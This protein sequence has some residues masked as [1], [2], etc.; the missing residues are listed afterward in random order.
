M[1]V[2]LKLSLASFRENKIRLLLTSLA[3]VAAATM[4]VWVG[5][6]YDALMKSFEDYSENALGHYQLSVAGISS[7]SQYAPG[8]IPR[9][10]MRFVP[11]EVVAD[12][13]ADPAVEAADPMWAQRVTIGVLRAGGPGGRPGAGPGGR[14]GGKPDSAKP[15]AGG[16]PPSGEAQGAGQGGGP[17]AGQRRGPPSGSERA[18]GPRRM[19]RT[20]SLRM[21]GTDA[22]QPP[23]PLASGRWLDGK[24]PSEAAISAGA[25]EMFSI[26]LGDQ[27]RVGEGPTS[28]VL[29]IV[30]VVD[31]PEI[32]GFVGRVAS[33]QL[34]T[35]SVG[36][37]YTSM[38]NAEAIL[39]EPHKISFVGV[40]VSE[41]ADINAFRYRWAAKLNSLATPCQF[42]EAHDLE[43]TLDQSA[44]A[45]N[46]RF[47]AYISTAISLLAALFII[48][49]ALSMGVTERSRQLAILRAVALT[50]SQI[51]GLIVIESLILG[52]IGFAGGLGAGQAT[53]SLAAEASP[54]LLEGGAVLGK[55]AVTLAAICAYGG[56]LFAALVPMIRATRVRPLDAMA[57]S[58]SGGS[59]APWL[60]VLIGLLLLPINLFI[61]FTMTAG[62][63]DRVQLAVLVGFPTMAVGTVL[64]APAVILF[65]DRVISPLL[66]RVLGIE[67]KLLAFQLPSNLWRAVGTAA[68][69]TVGLSLFIA[70]QVWGHTM[71]SSFLPA[72]WT[73][74]AVVAFRPDG[75]DPSLIDE[76]RAI[77]GVDA[78]RA[79]MIVSEQP[80]LLKDL[81][82][83][84]ERA[85]VVRQDNIVLVGIDP[86]RGYGDADPLFE[87][88]W[89][90]GDK[91]SAVAAM[92]QGRG[93]IVPDHFLAETGLD[94]GD[95]FE[96]VPPGKPTSEA[97]TYSVAGAV[98]LHGW[99]W[100]TKLTGFR[101]R[102]HRA[103]ALVFS[104]Y[105]SVA[106]D[107]DK[108]KAT[109]IWMS[110]DSPSAD[111]DV[112][113]EKMRDIQAKALGAPVEIS[114]A[115]P[116][117]PYVHI[118][119]ID[120]IYKAVDHHARQWLWAMSRLPLITL[121]ITC[122]GVLNLILASVRARRWDMGVM[123]SLGVTRSALVR[124]VV[125]EGV[126]VGVVACV[127]SLGLGILAGYCGAGISQYISFF[128]GLHPPLVI[129]WPELWFGLAV[130]MGLSALAAIGP[131]ISVGRAE[132]L[133]LLKQG[134]GAL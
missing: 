72:G 44:S 51:A 117:K 99:H 133:T 59:K 112:I 74:D 17:S 3:T 96:L 27:V 15:A 67:P 60:A 128:G 56:A 69:L 52:T 20:P 43:E 127:L 7:F 73:P 130:A 41:D 45:E 134:R 26:S 11:P 124:M 12:L 46:V 104:D 18:G 36:G 85:T 77:D 50:R 76:I 8:D 105:A 70:I 88:E 48:F 121:V 81:T 95:T 107:F 75:I 115:A 14:P 109:H 87:F 19:R 65:V 64:V 103:A 83:S 63:A 101:S 35:P 5:S 131:A 106:Q 61:T 132:P 93:C 114:K 118:V 4:V 102:T 91:D 30:G 120:D 22:G 71:L 92:K 98:R 34:M 62:D 31:L 57:P 82:G 13:K 90:K 23:F 79:E 108:A 6:G 21:L 38:A 58:A 86:E 89:I 37:L 39:T 32:D 123:R 16:A 110:Y 111:P 1:K 94:I 47:Q 84:A 53:L 24:S 54:R 119:P 80:R 28:K 55:N 126:L 49:S 113:A 9:T 29:T 100:Q 125:A 78:Q 116:G 42:Q 25:A 10:A 122:L 129:P 2:L 97:V 68:A 66:A 33:G 40:R